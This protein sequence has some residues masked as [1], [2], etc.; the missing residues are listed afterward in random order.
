MQDSLRLW[1]V[2]NLAI[3]YGSSLENNTLSPNCPYKQASVKD[4]AR[5]LI[6]RRA[7]PWVTEQKF[8][9]VHS[10]WPKAL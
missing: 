7:E 8:Y 10:A 4:S 5:P 1:N 3:L 6:E 9:R 2:T